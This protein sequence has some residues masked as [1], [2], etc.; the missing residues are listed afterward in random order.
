MCL[1][2]KAE[3]IIESRDLGGLYYSAV[4]AMKAVAPISIKEA[5]AKQAGN[6]SSA[7]AVQA[8]QPVFSAPILIQRKCACGGEC[9]SCQKEEL[10]ESHLIQTKLKVNTPGDAFEQ[11]AD[12]IADQVVAMNSPSHEAM[13]PLPVT[14]VTPSLA[15]RKSFENASSTVFY[16]AEKSRGRAP[17]TISNNRDHLLGSSCL[18]LLQRKCACSGGVPC[19][20]CED[21]PET[22]AQRKAAPGP[23]KNIACPE[24]LPQNL[25]L[26][27]PL[28]GG[29]RL[30]MESRFGSDFSQVRIHDG[31]NAASAA[32]SV[33]ALAYT[34]GHDIVFGEGRYA[35]ATTDGRKLLAH[36]LTHVL[37]QG[38]SSQ[39]VQRKEADL[40]NPFT[41][42][43]EVGKKDELDDE[44]RECPKAHTGLGD[45]PPTKPCFRPTHAG[46]T[47]L[48]RWFFCVDSDIVLPSEK[49]ERLDSQVRT[50]QRG[51]RFLVHGHASKEGNPDYNFRLSCH[52]ANK[53]GDRII[54]VLTDHLSLPSEKLEPEQVA[55]EV[56]S[57][58]EVGARGPTSEFSERPQD[59]R[60]VVVYGEIP[61]QTTSPEPDC[62]DAPQHLGDIKPEINCDPPTRDLT[63][64]NG[65]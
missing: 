36:E 18:P 35:P 27:R 25:G 24:T 17:P 10:E 59:N 23:G 4:E 22:L 56:Q 21:E 42:D 55:A 60:V 65:G 12:R 16:A 31:A 6:R 47:E 2:G 29:T 51:T 46:T 37:Q 34:V 57:R 62:K 64:M 53:I 1:I 11:E 30:F 39:V 19:S 28:D 54:K 50:Q 48:S 41:D 38:A 7:Q 32:Q 3:D 20:Q 58:V 63:Q 61:G 52:R 45:K 15:Q 43:A 13:A 8:P 49:L 14:P 40:S 26:G 9:P 33:N 44:P 5:L